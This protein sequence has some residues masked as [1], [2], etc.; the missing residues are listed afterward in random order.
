MAL[1][2]VVV[3]SVTLFALLCLPCVVAVILCADELFERAAR[4]WHGR[5][6]R[7]A[8]RRLDKHLDNDRPAPLPR[9]EAPR[10]T[11]TETPPVTPPD[12]PGPRA[13]DEGPTVEISGVV[14]PGITGTPP[15]PRTPGD[16]QV[17]SAAAQ[18]PAIEQIAA[19]LRRLHRQRSAGPTTE[20][21]A[22]LLAVR[23]AY[24]DR[25]RLAC[26]CLGVAEHLDDLDGLD[27][28]IERVRVEGEL[29]AAGLILRAGAN[30]QPPD[31]R[32]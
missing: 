13:D 9:L 15:Q 16:E 27:R 31:R 30:H 7:R 22:W 25:L 4:R 17:W 26:T 2:H 5:R 19:D 14:I 12:T 10:L 6:A 24:D 21:T 28:E 11:V 8:L 23:R 1:T 3:L 20:S 32:G 29:E 18:G